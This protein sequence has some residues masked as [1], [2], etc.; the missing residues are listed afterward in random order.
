MYIAPVGT[1]INSQDPDIRR[2]FERLLYPLPACSKR[3]VLHYSSRSIDCLKADGLKL[4]DYDQQRLDDRC[5]RSV[6]L[7]DVVEERKRLSPLNKDANHTEA[8]HEV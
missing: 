7:V 2:R 8:T 6:M 1:R 3:L 4:N 5:T